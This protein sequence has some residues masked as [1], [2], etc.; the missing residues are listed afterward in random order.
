MTAPKPAG[1]WS[2][3]ING[4]GDVDQAQAMARTWLAEAAV[5]HQ[6]TEQ[7]FATATENMPI[8]EGA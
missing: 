2:I 7:R 5:D 4:T 3:V 8:T 6:I 1:D